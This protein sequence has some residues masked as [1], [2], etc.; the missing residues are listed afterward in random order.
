MAS[1]GAKIDTRRAGGSHCFQ[2]H[3]QI[4]QQIGSLQPSGTDTRQYKQFY[5]LD[6]TVAADERMGHV[7][8]TNCDEQL[9]LCLSQLLEQV[10]PYAKTFRMMKDRAKI[11]EKRAHEETRAAPQVHLVFNI[12]LVLDRRQYNTSITDE[13]VVENDELPPTLCFAIYYKNGQKKFIDDIDSRCDPL[14]YPL[15]FPK[16]GSG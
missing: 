4:Y 6:S 16:G 13:V 2:I 11:E 3:G 9:M 5:I 7:A 1:M 10:N 12:G 15:L 14:T 8:N